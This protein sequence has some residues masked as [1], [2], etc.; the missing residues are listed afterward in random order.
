MEIQSARAGSV[1]TCDHFAPD[2]R[3][4]RSV[5]FNR[6]LAAFYSQGAVSANAVLDWVYLELLEHR[7][8]V[9]HDL[10]DAPI[11]LDA[12]D[13]NGDTLLDR[14]WGIDPGRFINRYRERVRKPSCHRLK[15]SA[16]LSVLLL[17]YARQNWLCRTSGQC[18]HRP[19]SSH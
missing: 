8:G 19:L 9:L 13:M 4:L 17:H 1:C 10:D 12:S 6:E 11:D 14:V 18:S 15:L 7:I 3:L 2:I 5:R 16:V